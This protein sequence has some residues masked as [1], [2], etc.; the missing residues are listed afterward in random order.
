MSDSNI[1]AEGTPAGDAD[2]PSQGQPTQSAVDE[3]SITDL[4]TEPLTQAYVK[5]IVAL[6]AL[7]GAGMGLLV[8]F[9]DIIDESVFDISGTGDGATFAFVG[10][11]TSGA[12]HIAA[13][14]ALVVGGYLAVRMAADDKQTMITGAAGALAGTFLLWFS[15]RHRWT[16]RAS[17]SA[18]CSSTGS[19]S[20]CW[21]AESPPGRYTSCA[22]SFPTCRNRPPDRRNHQFR[23]YRTER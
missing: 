7:L 5:A 23:S 22:T 9:Y 6:Y 21:S 8:I 11:P 4:L 13:V 20:D 17:S 12:P 14:L 2:T 16:V 3:E 1:E 10:V 19:S 15:Q 18:A